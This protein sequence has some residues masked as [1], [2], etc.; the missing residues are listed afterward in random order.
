MLNN[1]KYLY[2]LILLIIALV[3]WNSKRSRSGKNRVPETEQRST[4]GLAEE[5]RRKSANISFSRHARCRMECRRI[6]ETEVRE[7]LAEGSI[8][9]SRIEES[10]KGLSVPLE[11]VTHDRQHVRIVV[12][13]K[14]NSLV[15][16][17]VIDLDTDWPC[18]CP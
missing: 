3:L 9:A 12:A 6:D 5:I 1:K 16:V 7:V 17:T 13:P 11:G 2:V 10:E 4:I 8:N 14:Q 15:L 18:E